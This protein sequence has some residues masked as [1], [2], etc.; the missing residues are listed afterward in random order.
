MFTG[1][2]ECLGKVA[3]LKSQG[4]GCLLSLSNPLFF[5]NSILGASIAINGVCLTIVAKKTNLVLFDVG[6]ETLKK[7]NLG[8][9][10]EGDLVNLEKP[11]STKSDFSGHFVQGHIDTTTKLIKIKQSGPWVDIWFSIPDSIQP[12]LVSKGSICIDG[13]SLTVVDVTKN[14]FSVALIPHTLEKTSLRNK[15][16]GDIVNIEADMIAKYAMRAYE[17]FFKEKSKS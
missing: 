9:L 1:I 5:K 3:G 7:T 11:V 12:F 14:K 16:P 8:L 10:K 6:P 4:V 17:L 2:V 13:V 15:G